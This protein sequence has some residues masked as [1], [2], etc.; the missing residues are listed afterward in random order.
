MGRCVH[1]SFIISSVDTFYTIPIVPFFLLLSPTV[2]GFLIL[3]SMPR[4]F[5]V[6]PQQIPLR[7]VSVFC[8]FE[9]LILFESVL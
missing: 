7:D 6:M 2:F 3:I 9:Q 1:I 4:L 5:G 8:L